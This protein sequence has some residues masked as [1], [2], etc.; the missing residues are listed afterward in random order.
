MMQEY[1]NIVRML[2]DPKVIAQLVKKS[3]KYIKPQELL[4]M[5]GP[6]FLT[7]PRKRL[8]LVKRIRMALRLIFQYD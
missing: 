2:N 6:C 1:A 3:D 4:E 7:Q 5:L 8:S